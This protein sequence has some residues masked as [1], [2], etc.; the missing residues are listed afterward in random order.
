VSEVVAV[1]LGTDAGRQ[2][3]CRAALE[4]STRPV[5]AVLTDLDH[6]AGSELVWMLDGGAAPR[7]DALQRLLGALEL[8]AP[9]G[10]AVL[11]AGLVVLA[12]G[13]PVTAT[14]AAGTEHDTPAVLALAPS[15]VLPIRRASLACTLVR[16]GALRR[17]GA[18]DTRFGPY[19][20]QEWTARIL[21]DAPGLLVPT[22]VAELAAA[23][24]VR[25]APATLRAW[26]RTA[27]TPT[28]TKGETARAL[29]AL[30]GP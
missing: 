10:P 25:R 21:R 19:A 23:P 16:G 18:P 11:A 6:A 3:A 7:P 13:R 15:R 8:P 26:A 14:L 12:D 27:R 4:R 22:A 29:A 5:D 20:G 24:R 9:R 30:K 28:W 17:H 1:I 2:A